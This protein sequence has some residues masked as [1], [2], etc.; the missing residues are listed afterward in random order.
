MSELIKC[1]FSLLDTRRKYTGRHRQYMID[2][3][4]GICYSPATRERIQN[5]EALGFYGHGRR[6]L[7]RKMDIEEVDVI[8]LPDGQQ[9]MVSNVPSNVTTKFDVAEDGTVSHSQEILDTETGRIVSG[10]NASKVGGFSWA[11]PGKDGGTKRPTLLTGFSGFDYVLS[12]GF[13]ANRGYVLESARGDMVLE[14]VAAIVGND[15]RAE[16]LVAGWRLELHDHMDELEDA[17]FESQRR[18]FELEGRHRA[19]ENNL[20]T[21]KAEAEAARNAL[22]EEKAKFA[23]VLGRIADSLPF[24]IPENVM[25]EMLNGDFTRAQ[26]VFESAALVDYSQY[27]LGE[28]RRDATAPATPAASHQE[29]E[30][31]TASYGFELNL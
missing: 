25:H 15:K 22:A 16:Q 5:R 11:C 19:L 20:D 21:V 30:Y 7:C 18:Y 31:G 12:P 24:F 1:S 13:S 14:S 6:I 26:A 3:A 28:R 10:L 29:P 8:T 17:V 27:P 9:A 2:N 4:R 23:H